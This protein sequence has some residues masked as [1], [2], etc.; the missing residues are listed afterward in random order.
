MNEWNG[1]FTVKGRDYDT[2][3]IGPIRQDII[4][5]DRLVRIECHYRIPAFYLYRAAYA[6][7]SVYLPFLKRWAI[8]FV[9]S[10][11]VGFMAHDTGEYDELVGVL[12]LDAL[13]IIIHLKALQTPAEA[14][15][16]LGIP[17]DAYRKLR[18]TL[19]RMI[20][21]ELRDYFGWLGAMYRIV[22]SQNRRT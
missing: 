16:S 1:D 13:S 7:D 3:L 15:E 14:E 21:G 17:A 5:A 6:G 22:L 19:V 8:G 11:L 9:D 4:D 2:E 20:D 18:A 10:A 12:A